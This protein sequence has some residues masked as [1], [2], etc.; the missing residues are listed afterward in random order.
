MATIGEEYV[1][2][3]DLAKQLDTKGEG[4]APSVMLLAQSN[5]ILDDMPVSEC[6]MTAAH[7]VFHTTKLPKGRLQVGARTEGRA[8]RAAGRPGAG[9]PDRHRTERQQ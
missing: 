5:P 3:V 1:T 7:R 6:N 8:D 2:I 9:G 4:I